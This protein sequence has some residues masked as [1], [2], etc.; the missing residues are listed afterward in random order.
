MTLGSNLLSLC[1]VD[2]DS[3]ICDKNLE[4]ARLC[5]CEARDLVKKQESVH[6]NLCKQT[7]DNSFQA[8]AIRRKLLLLRG[9]AHVNLGI[10]LFELSLMKCPEPVRKGLENEATAELQSA[11]SC[12]NSIRAH[13]VTDA[14]KGASPSEIAMD[15]LEADQ[16]DALTNRWLGKSLWQKRKRN[17]AVLACERG[18]RFFVDRND[19]RVTDE[20]LPEAELELGVECFYVCT[21][22][23]D[24]ALDTL[25][26][27]QIVA[28]GHPKRQDCL[29]SGQELLS[30]ALEAYKRASLVSATLQK[31]ATHMSS[32]SSAKDTLRSNG[33]I[34]SQ[35]I[36]K[37][38]EQMKCWW[39]EKKKVGIAVRQTNGTERNGSDQ[40]RNDLFSS[41]TS[42]PNHSNTPVKRFTVNES[43]SRR[44][45]KRRNQG[46]SGSSRSSTTAAASSGLNGSRNS[47]S[48]APIRYRKWGD[49][50]LPQRKTDSGETVP[51]MSYEYPACAPPLPPGFTPYKPNQ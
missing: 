45:S 38:A 41:G 50:L 36:E 27:L 23:A 26:K 48:N 43:S 12:A 2:K 18:S 49:A 39:E 34:T 3:D 32:S 47:T 17:D 16:L 28:Q 8:R 51:L 6:L 4:E 46:G 19:D 29:A 25:E 11:E 9:R 24:L 37:N 1:A 21:S 40:L 44:A 31:L 42:R 22:L 10:A 7:N 33:I 14:T 30:I 13:A 15:R 35:E 20:D 5:F